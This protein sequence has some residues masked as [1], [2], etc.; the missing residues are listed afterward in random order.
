ME[1]PVAIVLFI[2][3]LLLAA[4]LYAFPVATMM[5]TGVLCLYAGIALAGI[6]FAVPIANLAGAGIVEGIGTI[7]SGVTLLSFGATLNAILL[8]LQRGGRMGDD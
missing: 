3:P 6:G 2:S 1:N 8:A 5:V 7:I 4:A